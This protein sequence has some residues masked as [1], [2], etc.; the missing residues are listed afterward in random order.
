MKWVLHLAIFTGW[1]NK[2]GSER[3][4]ALPISGK[5]V[6]GDV[7]RNCRIETG[8]ERVAWIWRRLW[9]N[10][11]FLRMKILYMGH[12]G[13][14]HAKKQRGRGFELIPSGAGLFSSPLFTQWCILNSGPLM[15]C[16]TTESF[17][18][19]IPS[20]ISN[21]NESLMEACSTQL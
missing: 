19:N 21:L 10:W 1:D 20:C 13:R 9:K 8:R 6:S 16:N 11:T 5:Y 18:Y 15:R 3:I 4:S 12:S 7:S 2:I 17:H 14:A